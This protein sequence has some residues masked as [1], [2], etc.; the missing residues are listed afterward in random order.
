MGHLQAH[1]PQQAMHRTKAP[2]DAFVAYQQD[3]EK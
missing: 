1:A 3:P 2:A